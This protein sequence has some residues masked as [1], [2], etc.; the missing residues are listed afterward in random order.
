M[1]AD[2]DKKSCSNRWFL[3][4]PAYTYFS[5]SLC[6]FLYFFLFSSYFYSKI[7]NVIILSLFFLSL[8]LNR[9]TYFVFPSWFFLAVPLLTTRNKSGHDVHSGWQWDRI[10]LLSPSTKW[11]MIHFP[12]IACHMWID[13]SS[14]QLYSLP[15]KYFLHISIYSYIQNLTCKPVFTDLQSKGLFISLLMRMCQQEQFGHAAASILLD[16]LE[17]NYHGVC[18]DHLSGRFHCY[19]QHHL[20]FH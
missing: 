2:S 13:S 7:I 9:C 1:V 20:L 8:S 12:L 18:C 5:G 17:M 4:L 6:S 19:V 11:Q 10:Y 16:L 15:P 14:L 3:L